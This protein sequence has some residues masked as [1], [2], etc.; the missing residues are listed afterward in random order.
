MENLNQDREWE[1]LK[2][3]GHDPE[4]I[5][6][7]DRRTSIVQGGEV[8]N[9]S[10]HRDQLQRHY[11]LLSICGLALTIDNAWVA[12]GGSIAVSISTSVDHTST[13]S[14]LLT[15]LLLTSSIPSAGGVY[16]WAS[17]T[18]GPRYGR[19]LG[20]F[21]GSLNFFGWIF[22][23]ASIVSIPSNVAVQMYAVFHPDLI[24]KPWH[25]YV[26]FILITWSCCALVVFGNRLL[27]VLNQ[28]GLF[29]VIVGGLVTII[30]VAAMPKVHASNSA[31]WGDFSQNNAAGWSNGVTF[32]TGVL[33]GAFTIGTPD[34]V[35]HM[36]EELPNPARDMPRAVGAQ[37]ILGT[38]TSFLYAIAI[39]YGVNDLTA[40]VG[41]NG[42]FPLAVVYSQATGNKGATFGLLLILFLS[43]MICVL[44]TFLTVGR[45]WWAL[46]RDN[47][48]PFSGFFSQVNEKLSCPVPATVLAAFLCTCFGAIQL[49]SKTAFTDL[50]GS[51][52]ILTTM[53]YA[54]AIGPHLFTGRKNV[55]KGPFWMGSAGYAVNAIAVLL[56][57]F[58]NI[59][60][61]FPYVYPTTE[62][63][64]NYN[65]VILVGVLILTIAWWFI[66]ARTKYPG[67]KLANL[68]VDG[69]IVELPKDAH[70]D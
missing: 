5:D 24:I 59:M 32:L 62:S 22:D 52:I 13:L 30:V 21:T 15:F 29:L 47:A 51:F 66:H 27:P 54:L 18:P 33:N 37:I 41:S 34:A 9:A 40:V 58:F 23:L 1:D 56:I 19:V 14:P 17:V 55:P 50:V 7:V 42:S 3:H 25:V 43:I 70:T 49:G 65:S 26:A 60:F 31:V 64:M 36:S 12:L 6:G 11:G 63:T 67:P 2:A 16:H 20:F 48:T 8:I 46:A 39:L 28:I 61:C 45:I 53:S 69:Q 68:Y 57:V 10:G 35:T 44:G 38:L 4:K